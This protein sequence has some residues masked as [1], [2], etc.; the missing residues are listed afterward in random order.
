[1]YETV[2]ATLQKV[3]QRIEAILLK[4]DV[5]VSKPLAARFRPI[6]R[7]NNFSLGKGCQFQ[8][9]PGTSMRPK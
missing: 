2:I 5:R 1:M 8:V 3:G 6:L 7:R 9:T 4:D